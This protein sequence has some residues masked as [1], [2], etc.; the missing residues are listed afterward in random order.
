MLMMLGPSQSGKSHLFTKLSESD[1]WS[2]VCTTNAMKTGW[3]DSY[4][5]LVKVRS[6]K[7]NFTQ[8]ESSALNRADSSKESSFLFMNVCLSI[9]LAALIL[10]Y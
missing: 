5:G 7:Y 1:R 10:W 4:E 3:E 6:F 9:F 2:A 8:I